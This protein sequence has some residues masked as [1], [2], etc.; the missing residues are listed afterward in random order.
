MNDLTNVFARRFS[1]R[2]AIDTLI[3]TQLTTGTKNKRSALGMSLALNLDLTEE[4]ITK[5]FHITGQ[6]VSSKDTELVETAVVL[7]TRLDLTAEHIWMILRSKSRILRHSL[8]NPHGE[9]WNH[10]EALDDQMVDYLLSQ[11][12]FTSCDPDIRA[13]SAYMD[14][15][16]LSKE[17]SQKIRDV[18]NKRHPHNPLANHGREVDVRGFI[19]WTRTY[20]ERHD[21]IR[22]IQRSQQWDNYYLNQNKMVYPEQVPRRY[23]NALDRPIK[24]LKHTSWANISGFKHLSHV[25]ENAT[26]GQNEDFY[27]MFFSLLPEWTGSI[28]DLINSASSLASE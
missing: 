20:E 6:L 28:N 25:V 15:F 19:T 22:D 18:Y 16:R 27:R 2:A 8:L 4:Q 14:Y 9:M 5:M 3:N 1:S 21:R 7:T 11:K 12:W 13:V 24:M 23:I 26:L 10:K 17:N